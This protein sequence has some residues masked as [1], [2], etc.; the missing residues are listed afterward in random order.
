[1]ILSYTVTPV[2]AHNTSQ[3]CDYP[4]C[5]NQTKERVAFK[6][7]YVHPHNI[8]LEDMPLAYYCETHQSLDDITECCCNT[9]KQR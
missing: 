7:H 5:T 4:D 6:Q 2:L 8:T 9:P 1:M 3:S